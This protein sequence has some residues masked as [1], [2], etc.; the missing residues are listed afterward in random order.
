MSHYDR[1]E[2][3]K[4]KMSFVNLPFLV[5]HKYACDLLDEIF[6]PNTN[7]EMIRIYLKQL[8]DDYHEH[9]KSL[10]TQLELYN[11]ELETKKDS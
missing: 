5:Q 10:S 8:L 3:I 1:I 7:I 9:N 6:C 11:N 2:V 4:I